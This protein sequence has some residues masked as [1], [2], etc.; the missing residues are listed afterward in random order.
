MSLGTSRNAAVGVPIAAMHQRLRMRQVS[1]LLAVSDH[2]T[3][4]AAAAAIGLSQPAATKMLA[5]LES[6]LG[7]RLFDRVGRGLTINEA[8][9]RTVQGFRGLRGTLRRLQD[10]LDE[11][12]LGRAGH[13]AVGSIMAASPTW[14]T[15]ALARLKARLPRV[16]V[17]VE[18]GTS[19]RLMAQ[20]DDGALDIVVGRAP[21]DGRDHVFRP[22]SEEPISIVAAHGHPLARVRHLGFE[23]LR[24]YPWV[25][26]PEGT[27][28][29][30]AVLQTFQRHDAAL[31]TGL[32]ETSSAMIT[33]H[34]VSR[35]KMIAALP[36]SVARGFQKHRML[37]RLAFP[38]AARLA[39]Y[40]SITRIDRPLSPQ[41]D[42]FLQLLHEG[43]TGE[44]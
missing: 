37:A 27:P 43:G 22:L 41:A 32:I 34:L 20:L 1:L 14:L 11:L 25:L 19:D 2:G 21:T 9:R 5:E 18:V 15:L 10:D 40:G 39:S 13:L 29:R 8:G 44:W 38:V 7:Q 6:T 35:T 17:L 16:S 3:L 30:E 24:D 33:V 4:G 42:H 36:E 28:I 26:Q 31:P 12:R 23:R